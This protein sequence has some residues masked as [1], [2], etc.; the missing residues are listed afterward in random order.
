MDTTSY[1][2]MLLPL[3]LPIPFGLN[4]TTKGTISESTINILNTTINGG[5]F[6]AK[7]ILAFNQAQLDELI[8]LSANGLDK[9]GNHLILPRLAAGQTWGS[10]ALCKVSCVGND[11]EDKAKMAIN[12]LTTCLIEIADLTLCSNA[13]TSP[14]ANSTGNMG[15]LGIDEVVL[16]TTLIPCKMP[17]SGS[18][19]TPKDTPLN[20]RLH[21]RAKLANLG[22]DRTAETL[23]LPTLTENEEW[24]Y[25]SCNHASINKSMANMFANIP[26]TLTSSTYFLHHKVNLPHRNPLV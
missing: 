8:R 13:A 3:A 22:W 11:E 14:V 18:D 6:W 9:V 2:V 23:Q 20:D 25:Y 16:S 7:C 21:D 26:K 10:P 19:L 4:T 5:T 1:N 24:I 15:G 17:P 12:V